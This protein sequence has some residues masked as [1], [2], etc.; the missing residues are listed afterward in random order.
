MPLAMG[1]DRVLKNYCL[2]HGNHG[3]MAV[4]T[5]KGHGAHLVFCSV[6]HN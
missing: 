5:E 3:N 1:H 4:V 2:A 6:L